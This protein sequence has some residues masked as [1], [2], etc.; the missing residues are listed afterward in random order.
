[1]PNTRICDALDHRRTD[2]STEQATRS[3]DATNLLPVTLGT[4]SEEPEVSLDH[5][6]LELEH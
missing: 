3:V 2:E 4:S 1:M 5:G 6:T